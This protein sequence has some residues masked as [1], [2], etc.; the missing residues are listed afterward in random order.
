[1]KQK[2]Q[3]YAIVRLD[4]AHAGE[5]AV[6]VKSI[7]ST[8]DEAEREVVRLNQLNVHKGARYFWQATR[9]ATPLLTP[10]LASITSEENLSVTP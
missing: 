1:M 9:F 4:E 6:T 8:L 3:V 7:V 2:T 10:E 5:D